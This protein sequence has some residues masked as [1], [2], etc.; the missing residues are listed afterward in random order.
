MMTNLGITHGFS[1][2]IR[3][4]FVRDQAARQWRHRNAGQLV[5]P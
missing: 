4:V 3:S 2:G 5:P 1:S